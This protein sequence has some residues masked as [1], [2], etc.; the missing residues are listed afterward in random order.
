[1]FEIKITFV[2]KSECLFGIL[3]DQ[4]EFEVKTEVWVPFTRLRL[5][6]VFLTLDLIKFSKTPTI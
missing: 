3:V 2:S 6:L 5:G 4:G 1:M